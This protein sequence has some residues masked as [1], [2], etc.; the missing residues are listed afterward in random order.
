M[1]GSG[2][3]RERVSFS[4]RVTINP[5]APDDYG[6]TQSDWV[7]QFRT[8]AQ[9]VHLRG[10]EAVLAGRLAGEHT[11]VVRV[12]SSSLTREIAPDWKMMDLTSEAEF[13]VR[14]VTHLPDRMWI[15]LLCQSGVAV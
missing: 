8:R 11:Q 9:F 5:D 13:N 10:G 6:N 4:Q 14:D 1:T 15:D 3:L 2:D 7:E 12:R